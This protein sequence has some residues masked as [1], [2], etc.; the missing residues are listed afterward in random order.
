MDLNRFMKELKQI[1]LVKFKN[2]LTPTI[3]CYWN[4]VLVSP[5]EYRL[6]L[7][8]I[9]ILN[10]LVEVSNLVV[11]ALNGGVL[12]SLGQIWLTYISF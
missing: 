11:Y 9:Q 2:K 10:D 8:S 5:K 4:M 6:S 1:S 12:V 7:C 3:V